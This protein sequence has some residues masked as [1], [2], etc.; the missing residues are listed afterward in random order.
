MKRAHRKKKKVLEANYLTGNIP[1]LSMATINLHPK[2]AFLFS[3]DFNMGSVFLTLL[4]LQITINSGELL[5][6]L[7]QGKYSGKTLH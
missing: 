7:D 3:R 1:C 2:G 4:L 5:L 6:C